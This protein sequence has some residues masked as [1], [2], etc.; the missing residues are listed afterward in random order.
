M[1]Q[2]EFWVIFDHPKDFPN[3]FVARKFLNNEPTEECLKCSDLE[4]LRN[5]FRERYCTLIPRDPAD[6]TVIIES[7]MV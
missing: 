5:H 1:N 4:A 6:N 2:V 7:W 3:D